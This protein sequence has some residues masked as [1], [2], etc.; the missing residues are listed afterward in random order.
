[1][2][3]RGYSGDFPPELWTALVLAH[4]TSGLAVQGDVARQLATA[5]ALGASLGWLSTIAP[6]GKTYAKRWRISP[7]GLQALYHKD[8]FTS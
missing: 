4:T 6:N 1:M 8:D 7:A 2:S 3:L 5:V